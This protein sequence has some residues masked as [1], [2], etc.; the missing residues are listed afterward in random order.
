MPIYRGGFEILF[1]SN[2]DNKV[3]YRWKT[4]TADGTD[5]AA[6]L[7]AEGEITIKTFYLRVPIIEY[8]SEPQ[9]KLIEELLDNSYFFQF[10][11]WQC[12]Q[13]MKVS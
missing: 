1:T 11:K 6:S 4:K 5:D 7:P 10:K 3:I 2:S 9:I 8:N 12:I 13:Q